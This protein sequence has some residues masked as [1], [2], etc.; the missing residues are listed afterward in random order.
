[1]SCIRA[2]PPARVVPAGCSA[3]P[4]I[5]SA[6]VAPVSEVAPSRPTEPGEPCPVNGFPGGFGEFCRSGRG[7]RCRSW[8]GSVG[9]RLVG[10]IPV[11]WTLSVEQAAIGGRPARSA[12]GS[13]DRCRSVGRH[14][15]SNPLSAATFT[16]GSTSRTA[17]T[18]RTHRNTHRNHPG[19]TP[20][21]IPELWPFFSAAPGVAAS[22][23]GRGEV[24]Q[25][26]N[27]FE[28][29]GPRSALDSPHHD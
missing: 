1:M 26:S 8:R 6:R 13:L 4:L 28:P 5:P 24:C 15:S 18:Y 12:A 2:I 16:G 25:G 17:Q 27:L 14:R 10:P 21:G 29:E 9:C 7:P 19:D 3:F 11:Y 20:H 23:P 22:F